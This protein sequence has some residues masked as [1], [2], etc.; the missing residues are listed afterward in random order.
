MMISSEEKANTLIHLI[1]FAAT[2]A[3][4]WPLLRLAAQHTSEYPYALL[5]TVLFLVGSRKIYA[6][7]DRAGS[8]VQHISPEE[9]KRAAVRTYVQEPRKSFKIAN[10]IIGACCIVDLASYPLVKKMCEKL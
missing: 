9:K 5:G 10:G 8:W 7:I 1:P 3:L 2:L 6:E 4:A